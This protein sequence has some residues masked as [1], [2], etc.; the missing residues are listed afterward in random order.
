M[1]NFDD[2]LQKKVNEVQLEKRRDL[3]E[4]ERKVKTERKK[5]T[6]RYQLLLDGEKKNE[7][8]MA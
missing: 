4:M 1:K 7:E 8:L 6:R 2:M 5:E 3:E